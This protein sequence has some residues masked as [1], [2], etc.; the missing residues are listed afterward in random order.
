MRLVMKNEVVSFTTRKPI[1]GEIE[2]D[3]NFI[4]L[5]KFKELMEKGKLS[6]QVKYSV[7]YYVIDQ[8]DF[9]NKLSIGIAFVIVSRYFCILLT[10]RHTSK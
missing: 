2:V 8:E 7:N 9:E 5:E 3:Y 10:I 1:Q 6:E 4:S